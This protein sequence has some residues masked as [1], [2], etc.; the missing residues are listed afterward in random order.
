MEIT[1]SDY[2]RLIYNTHLRISRSKKGLPFKYRKDFNNL[3]NI[4]INSLKKIAIFLSKFPHIKL[5]DFIKAPYEIYLDEQHFELDYY[6]TLKA[7]KAYTL[8]QKRIES[9]DPDTE[10]QLKNIIESLKFI[11][12]FCKEINI[13]TE[14]YINHIS[15]TSPSYILHLKEHRI[16]V[17]TLFGFSNFER[18]IRAFDQDLLKFVLGE[19][20]LNN[21]SNFRLKFFSSKTAKKL[22][23]LGLQ[24]IKS[25]T[26]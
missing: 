20:F 25:K 12:L 15:G 4:Y 6:T 10:E 22:V 9:M 26:T 14:N 8:Y 11:S 19:E 24:K 13:D 17:Y 23:E 21:F 1:L 5:E 7:T 2:E 18:S 16:N 3:D